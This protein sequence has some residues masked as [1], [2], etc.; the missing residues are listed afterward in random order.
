[1]ESNGLEQSDLMITSI[2]QY[3]VSELYLQSRSVECVENE[4]NTYFQ[5]KDME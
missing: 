5:S 4:F 2:I 3:V 1:M